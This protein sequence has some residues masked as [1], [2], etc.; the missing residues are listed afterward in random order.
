MQLGIWVWIS[1]QGAEPGMLMEEP[2]TE[3]TWWKYMMEIILW[4]RLPVRS[5]MEQEKIGIHHPE[6]S[7][8][9]HKKKEL[10]SSK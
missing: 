7:F 9:W 3:K 5:Y 6:T 1:S 4:V 8:Y 10:R 2:L